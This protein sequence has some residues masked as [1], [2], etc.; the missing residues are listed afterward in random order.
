[1]V[2]LHKKIV[3]N[4]GDVHCLVKDTFKENEA[5]SD[6]YEQMSANL[7]H[8]TKLNLPTLESKSW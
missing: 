7:K 5:C 3:A 1:M 6:G 8:Q 4:L 2:T